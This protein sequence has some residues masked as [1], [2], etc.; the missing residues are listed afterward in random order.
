MADRPGPTWALADTQAI[1]K[2]R[3]HPHNPDLV[4]V[5][6][7]GH[8]WGP[9]KERGVYRSKDGGQTWEQVLFRSEKAGAIDLS[10]DPHNPR[11]LYAS[12]W[13]AQRYPYKL[14]SGGPGSGIFKST[15]GGDNWTEIT[16]NEGLPTGVLGKIG[17]A[18][19]PAQSDRV[20]AIVEAEDGA[21]FRSD[22]GGS[23]WQRLSEQ[24]DLRWRAWYYQHIVAD[25]RDADVVWIMNGK[26]LEVD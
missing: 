22:D 21:L 20:Y 3:I 11:I 19:S 16:R 4:Y 25:P 18:A 14:N 6:A 2:V 5:A 23:T 15:D 13:E 10:M 26:L 17:I 9:N 24:N 12:I 8:V 1:A 7:L